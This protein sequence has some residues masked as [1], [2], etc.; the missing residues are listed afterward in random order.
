MAGKFL[1]SIDEFIAQ[2]I[3]WHA[4]F[5]KKTGGHMLTLKFVPRMP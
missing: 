2:V 4:S 3:F 5:A 1:S